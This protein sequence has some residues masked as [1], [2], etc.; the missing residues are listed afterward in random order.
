MGFMCVKLRCLVLIGIVCC[1]MMR[2]APIV[3]VL[4]SNWRV[5]HIVKVAII[6]IYTTAL[7]LA[8]DYY[9]ELCVD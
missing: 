1:R 9:A 8:P 3:V 4:Q 6:K 7:A 2:K 5:L